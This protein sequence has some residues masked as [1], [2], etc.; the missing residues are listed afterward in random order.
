MSEQSETTEFLFPGPKKPRIDLQ[1]YEPPE[2]VYSTLQKETRPWESS[3]EEETE[4]P[5]E[6]EEERPLREQ[7]QQQLREQHQLRKG[8]QHLFQQLV[9]TQQGVH[10]NPCLQ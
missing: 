3:Q 9:K 7:L 1:K 8:I 5:S 2:D 4:A 6:E 10:V